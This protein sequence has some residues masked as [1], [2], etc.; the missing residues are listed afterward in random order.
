MILMVQKHFDKLEAQRNRVLAE[1]GKLKPEQQLFRP[2]PD[3]WSML[4]VFDHLITAETNG[5]R[6]MEK[7]MLGI[8]SVQKTTFGSRWRSLLLNIALK[9]PL[10]FKAP[11]AAAIKRKDYYDFKETAAQWDALR[12]EWREFLDHFDKPTSE[13]LIFKHPVVGKLNISQTIDF[14]YEHV[15]HHEKQIARLKSC[16][17][18]PK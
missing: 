17:D 10:K 9:L 1:V 13:K 2:T 4:E 3:A 12:N 11:P 15:A 6:Y 7:K 5:L 18:Y 14:I 16:P 8:E